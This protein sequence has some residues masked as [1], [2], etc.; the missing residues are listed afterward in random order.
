MNSMPTSA[1]PAAG[2]AL[3]ELRGVSKRYA[4]GT[5]A[6][7]DIS[8]AV[9]RG[10]IHAIV[11]ENGAG[12]STVM[13]ILY[14]L[15][16]PSA[17]QI[18]LDGAVARLAGPRAA[19][20]AGIG[21]V[22]QHLKLVPSF[23][24]AQNIVLGCEPMRGPLLDTERAVRQV[25]ELAKRFGLAVEPRARVDGLSIGEQ[26]R[27]EILKALYRGARLVLM[28][29]PSAVLTPQE[30]Q[31]LFGTLRKLVDQG[32][33]VMLITHKLGEVREVSD[34]FTVLR[35]GRVS[36]HGDARR[37][38]ADELT[39]MIVGRELA[40][41]QAVRTGR[42]ES[43][44]V[45]L[46]SARRIGLRRSDGRKA[47]DDISFDI[48]AGEIL[49]IAGVEGNGQTELADILGGLCLAGEGQASVDG[50]VF[51]GRGVRAARGAGVAAIPEDRLHDGVAIDM[52][53]T[54]NLIAADYHKA[55]LSRFGWL[56]I[57]RA[58]TLAL[59]LIARYGVLASSPDAPIGTLSGGNM[60]KV[61]LARE[62]L[63]RPRFLVASQPTRGVD[64]GASQSL[65]AR[66]VE[67]RDAGA[68]VLLIS[69]DLD[70]ILALSDRIAVLARG[71]IVG[72]FV[73][74]GVSAFDLG[75]YMTGARAQDG[76][77]ALLGAPLL[78]APFGV[79]AGEGRA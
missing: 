38:G 71:R 1:S 41:A 10:E 53:I 57:D 26:Q 78:A 31:V 19:I 32:L 37:V 29:E 74:G 59:Q 8:F 33:T 39:T 48:A 43:A 40:P 6:N 13:K 9:R 36:G 56:R 69:S 23:T 46:V 5:L 14:G 42:R 35:G 47:L 79:A 52:S 54:D 22:P 75:P 73:G 28:D 27:V 65:R 2:A 55:P 4:N 7:D 12:K 50:L 30:A 18:F 58:R 45:A 49:G 66:L 72:H 68:A 34:R 16:Q 60:Q 20:A 77:S 3:I 67:L 15:E 25:A 51:T 24:V 64:I 11:G 44:G 21:L 63:A 62:L 61:V 70:E 17:G 76:A